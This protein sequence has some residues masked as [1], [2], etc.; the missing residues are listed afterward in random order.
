M[1]RYFAFPSSTPAGV[2]N[3]T[4]RSPFRFGMIGPICA[5]GGLPIEESIEGVVLLEAGH[6]MWFF[7]MLLGHE[8]RA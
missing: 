2:P 3:M 5:A 4:G 7:G 1:D 8:K 6:R